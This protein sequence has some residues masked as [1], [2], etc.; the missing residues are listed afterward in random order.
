MV[1]IRSKKACCG[2]LISEN[3]KKLNPKDFK[4]L[5]RFTRE[6]LCE[7]SIIFA[8]DG[9]CYVN[10]RKVGWELVFSTFETLMKENGNT[11]EK[12]RKEFVENYPDMTFESWGEQTNNGG[13]EH[14]ES[15]GCFAGL[16]VPF[17]QKR[18]EIETAYYNKRLLIL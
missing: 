8:P 5:Y 9:K 11:L 16:M 7:E 18:R 4:P 12:C 17:E 2:K 15:V 3:F 10:N 6:G 13:L 14:K 1:G